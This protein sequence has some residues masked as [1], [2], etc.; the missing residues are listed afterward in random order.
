[1]ENAP[2]DIE[3]SRFEGGDL[4]VCVLTKILTWS[5]R[6]PLLNGKELY[7]VNFTEADGPEE[8]WLQ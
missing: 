1:M 8:S 6:V 3:L 2:L 7:Q 4:N 5:M